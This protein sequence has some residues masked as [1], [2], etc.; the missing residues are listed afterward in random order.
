MTA[1]QTLPIEEP[2]PLLSLTE[3]TMKNIEAIK[4]ELDQ[5]SS[6]LKALESLGLDTSVMR[7]HLNWGYKAR[8]VVLKQFGN[9]G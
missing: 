8:D 2:N 4:K 1:K 7:E 6:D 3:E 9:K 5:A